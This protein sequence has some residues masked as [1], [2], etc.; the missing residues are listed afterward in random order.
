MKNTM[1][2]E[3]KPCCMLDEE[4]GQAPEAPEAPGAP[5]EGDGNGEGVE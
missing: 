4:D 3:K 2:E 5:A 1:D